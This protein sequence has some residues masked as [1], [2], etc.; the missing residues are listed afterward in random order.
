MS[1]L[2]H[3]LLHHQAEGEMHMLYGLY[4]VCRGQIQEVEFIMKI[5]F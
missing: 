1:M 5:K 2:N 3:F 4:P